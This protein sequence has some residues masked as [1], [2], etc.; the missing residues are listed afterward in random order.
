MGVLESLAIIRTGRARCRRL[1]HRNG[2]ESLV[3]AL[4]TL[5]IGYRDRTDVTAMIGKQR[6]AGRGATGQHPAHS[7]QDNR[8]H[9]V[10]HD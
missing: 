8:E 7:Q 10:A 9:P 3:D 4:P 5:R 2:I 6:D 1:F